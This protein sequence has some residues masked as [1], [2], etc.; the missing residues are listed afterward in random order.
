MIGPDAMAYDRLKKRLDDGRS[1]IL[2][3]AT[4][5]AVW[6][7]LAPPTAADDGRFLAHYFADEAA[8]REEAVVEPR[9]Q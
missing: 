4:G 7:R 1:V 3:G 9:F 2:D 8:T 6:Q 5:T